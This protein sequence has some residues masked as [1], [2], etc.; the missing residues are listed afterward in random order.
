MQLGCVSFFLVIRVDILFL[1]N[2][3]SFL[4]FIGRGFSLS[5]FFSSFT[6]N[7]S[8]HLLGFFL[9]LLAGLVWSGLVWFVLFCFVFFYFFFIPSKYIIVRQYIFNISPPP[10]HQSCYVTILYSNSPFLSLT[11][12]YV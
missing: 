10:S 3:F 9:G 11:C 2:F 5:C 8:I 4:F 12:M 1:L 7:I 6:A